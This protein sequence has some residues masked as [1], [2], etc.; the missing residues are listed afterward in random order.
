[1][2]DIKKRLAGDKPADARVALKGD[3]TSMD[4]GR[5]GCPLQARCPR[6]GPRCAIECPQLRELRPGRWSACHIAGAMLRSSVAEQST[7]PGKFH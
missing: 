2:P 5:P 4:A 3:V 6:V 1:V 7:M